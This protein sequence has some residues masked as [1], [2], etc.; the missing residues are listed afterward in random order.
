MSLT[1]KIAEELYMQGQNK[2]CCAK[3]FLFG[4]LYGSRQ[5]EDGKSYIASFYRESDARLA[6]NI[7]NTRF[8]SGEGTRR[9]EA[10]R[11]GHRTYTV[12]FNSK[13]LCTFLYAVDSKKETALEKIIGFRCAD[14]ASQFLRGLFISSAT[15]STP[16]NGY[17][18]EFSV[19]NT[20]RAECLRTLLECTVGKA[21]TVKR[22]VRIGLYYKRSECI[23]DLL[24]RIGAHS[25]CFDLQNFSIN[26]EIRNDEN[27]ATNC[28]TYNISR[29]VSSNKRCIDAIN[30]IKR[31]HATARL[32]EELLYTANLRLEHDDATLS[33]LAALHVPPLSKSGLNTRLKRIIQ[34]ADG[35]DTK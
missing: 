23:S 8:P 31:C 18:L 3:A 26:R 1:D 11:G 20:Q 2:T 29:S 32:T 24:Y 12:T 10:F 4:L 19:Q 13:A 14:C 15:M 16:K 33:E 35:I 22:G 17:I 25:A 21:G 27:R 28:V 9:G 6:E 30:K 34:I 5:N 7:I